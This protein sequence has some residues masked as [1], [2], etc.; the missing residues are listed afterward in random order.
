MSSTKT[1]PTPARA[2]QARGQG[3][4]RKKPSIYEVAAQ[5]AARR[6]RLVGPG[7]GSYH[8]DMEGGRKRRRRTRRKSRRKSRKRRTRKGRRRRTKRRRR[9]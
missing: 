4:A 2:T 1:N 3:A 9:R 7:R 6:M 5:R 8:R